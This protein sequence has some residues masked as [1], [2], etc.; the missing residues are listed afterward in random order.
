MQQF[1]TF[2]YL[3]TTFTCYYNYCFASLYAFL[4]RPCSPGILYTSVPSPITLIAPT[5]HSTSSSIITA[6]SLYCHVLTTFIFN[7]CHCCSSDGLYLAS[8]SCNTFTT[9][10]HNTSSATI[11][12]FLLPHANYH[13]LV[14][15]HVLPLHARQFIPPFHLLYAFLQQYYTT[16]LR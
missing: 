9:I 8:I 5:L 4:R 2:N 1:F 14:Y 15:L 13:N 11:S 16:L 10:L 12:F 7:V 6:F 3:L